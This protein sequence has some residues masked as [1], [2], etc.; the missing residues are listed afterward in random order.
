MIVGQQRLRRGKVVARASSVATDD[1][2]TSGCGTLYV[3]WP[4]PKKLIA[5]GDVY[6]VTFTVVDA[7]GGRSRTISGQSRWRR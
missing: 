6:R 3:S 4:I 2:I 1:L 5:I 7:A